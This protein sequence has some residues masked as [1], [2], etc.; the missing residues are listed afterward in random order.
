MMH[1]DWKSYQLATPT[2]VR[3]MEEGCDGTLKDTLLDLAWRHDCLCK[4]EQRI[5]YL[6]NA[7]SWTRTPH[8]NGCAV[9][10]SG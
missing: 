4:S 10:P 9:S 5:L 1:T 3:Y 8:T 2:F 7:T 6:V